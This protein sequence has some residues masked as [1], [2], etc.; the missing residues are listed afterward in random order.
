M[1]VLNFQM[2]FNS[3]MVVLLKVSFLLYIEPIWFVI[4]LVHMFTCNLVGFYMTFLFLL[5]IRQLEMD[6]QYPWF[7]VK[8]HHD[9]LI[10][11]KH[12]VFVKIYLKSYS[13]FACQFRKNNLDCIYFTNILKKTLGISC[14]PVCLSSCLFVQTW[15]GVEYIDYRVEMIRRPCI[16]VTQCPLWLQIMKEICYD[17]FK[18]NAV[19]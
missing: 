10:H 19:G 18:D 17:Q 14:H 5:C 7:S 6:N 12:I 3:L 16:S 13:A 8:L 4:E 11:E 2:Q 15:T 1:I 9:S